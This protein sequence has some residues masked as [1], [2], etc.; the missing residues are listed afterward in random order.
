MTL[1]IERKIKINGFYI[2][3]GAAFIFCLFMAWLIG[4]TPGIS[5]TAANYAY[6]YCTVQFIMLAAGFYFSLSSNQ[7]SFSIDFDTQK[8]W[9][10][11]IA[12]SLHQD[13][14]L[15]DIQEMNLI[16]AYKSKNPNAPKIQILIIKFNRMKLARKVEIRNENDLE[17]AEKMVQNFQKHN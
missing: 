12:F 10:K 17:I 14:E 2:A 1:S 8:G 4:S 9:M 16:P 13:F 11:S 3:L 5:N 15:T 6:I 7:R